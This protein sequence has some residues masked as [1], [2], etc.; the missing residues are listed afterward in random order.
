MVHCIVIQSV[1]SRESTLLELLAY[2]PSRRHCYVDGHRLHRLHLPA[3][4]LCEPSPPS[5]VASYTA[6]QPLA[7]ISVAI[8]AT[9]TGLFDA[10]RAAFVQSDLYGLCAVPAGRP[11][12]RA[13][14][15]AA[16][17]ER[18]LDMRRNFAVVGT[19]SA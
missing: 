7:A 18:P 10:G 8:L 12:G 15:E 16:R 9:T 11:P 1:Q 2:S 17:R 3:A 14:P 13:Q 5:L 19:L 4:G 6:L